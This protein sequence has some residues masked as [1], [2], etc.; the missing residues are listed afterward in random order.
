MQLGNIEQHVHVDNGK[1]FLLNYQ[2][3]FTEKEK[4][5]PSI[6]PKNPLKEFRSGSH[7]GWRL[8]RAKQNVH[9]NRL[10]SIMNL[11]FRPHPAK[12]QPARKRP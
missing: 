7:Y 4:T 12:M 9:E 3:N 8:P 2:V 5:V 1:M 10:N 6:S 11:F